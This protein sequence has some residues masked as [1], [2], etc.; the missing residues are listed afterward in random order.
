MTSGYDNV[1][2]MCCTKEHDNE[3]QRCPLIYALRKQQCVPYLI[4]AL[5]CRMAMQNRVIIG[6]GRYVLSNSASH[7]LNKC[8]HI[9]SDVLRTIS[10][11]VSELL[12]VIMGLKILIL[13]LLPYNPGANEWTMTSTSCHHLIGL[14]E[15]CLN[16]HGHQIASK[17]NLVGFPMVTQN[18]CCLVTLWKPRCGDQ[19][20][21]RPQVM[22][23]CEVPY[24]CTFGRICIKN[25]R[26][27]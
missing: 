26:I 21:I 3:H 5:W 24:E 16:G 2:F 4:V 10:Q 14:A 22:G 23:P 15:I 8:W 6:S 19:T 27:K 17:S 13:K 25:D 18:M 12:F 9:I 1:F 7:Y 20:S 11:R